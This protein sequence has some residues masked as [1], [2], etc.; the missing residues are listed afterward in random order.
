M[1]EWSEYFSD[2]PEENPANWVNGRFI[3]P[4]SQEA[5]DLAHARRVQN[6]WQAKVATEQAALDAEI[7]EIIR[8]HSKD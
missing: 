7:Q 2:F 3:H 8:K 5:R 6:L 4:N 1:G